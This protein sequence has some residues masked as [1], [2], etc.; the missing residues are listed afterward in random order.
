MFVFAFIVF[1]PSLITSGVHRRRVRHHHRARRLH[2]GYILHLRRGYIRR[3]PCY[4][5]LLSY[6]R[7]SNCRY[8]RHQIRRHENH[9]LDS[10][11]RCD[12]RRDSHRRPLNHD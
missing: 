2:R 3:H 7:E 12:C 10:T 5:R 9:S 1:S 8:L 4:G 11:K 6:L